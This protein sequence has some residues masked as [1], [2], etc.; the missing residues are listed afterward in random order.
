MDS[1]DNSVT[2]GFLAKYY[3]ARN[4]YGTYRSF[5]GS[6]T[7]TLPAKFSNETQLISLLKFAVSKTITRHPAL[8]FGLVPKSDT[9]DAHFARL[10]HINWEDV[11]ELKSIKTSIEERNATLEKEIGIVHEHLWTDQT[12]KPGWKLVAIKYDTLVESSKST[13]DVIIPVHHGIADGGSVRVLHKSLFQYLAEGTE[14]LDM[15]STWPHLIPP[16]TAIPI[17]IEVAVPFPKTSK[18]TTSTTPPTPQPWAGN[19]P[20]LDPYVP[21]THLLILPADSLSTALSACRS[22]KITMTSLLHAL[23]LLYLSKT[24]SSAEAFSATT[25]YSMRRFSGV[26]DD[27]MVNHIAFIVTQWKSSLVDSLRAAEED[28]DEEKMVIQEVSQQFTEE[29]T[30]DLAGIPTVHSAGLIGFATIP[31]YDAYC[32]VG[33]KKTRIDETYEISNIGLV[34][35]PNNGDGDDK[36]KLE[37]LVFSQSPSVTGPAFEASVISIS[38]GPMVVAYTWQED[39]IGEDVVKGLAAYVQR[40]LETFG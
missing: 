21:R 40:R 4:T 18:P 30:S 16:T 2:A 1:S 33:L 13:I 25:P 20:R 28:S 26:S 12:Q 19:S 14:S 11:F 3:A 7:Y 8:C 38:E 17:P 5:A 31:D 23:F 9:S 10:P 37:K 39:V 27:E 32:Q 24:I 15:N 22:R 29:I 36:V 34:K 6:A 35:L